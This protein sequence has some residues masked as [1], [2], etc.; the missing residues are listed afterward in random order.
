MKRALQVAV[1]HGGRAG[2]RS[3]AASTETGI[4]NSRR[5]SRPVPAFQGWSVV[6]S[7]ESAKP[8]ATLTGGAPNDLDEIYRRHS[9]WLR[10]FL[11]RRVGVEAAEDLVQ[12]TFVRTLLA[13]SEIRDA[14]AFLARVAVNATR[15]QHRQAAARPQLAPEGLQSASAATLPEQID[16]LALKQAILSLPPRLRD[17]FLL[18]RFEG[19]TYDSIAELRG[20][21]V[22]TVEKRMT[23]AL[24]HVTARVRG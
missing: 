3:L 9:A 14:R 16:Q 2:V 13:R 21:S 22:K 19:L 24:R 23:Q 5:A 10:A 18:S 8:K 1:A 12:E 7:A 20:V 11:R 6:S 17:V 4:S 15:N